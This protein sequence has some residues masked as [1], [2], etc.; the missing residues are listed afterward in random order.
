MGNDSRILIE[1]IKWGW[2][3][4]EE[5]PYGD[6]GFLLI[7]VKFR[8]FGKSRW[9]YNTYVDTPCFRISDDDLHDM[10][11]SDTKT[12]EMIGQ[13]YW[14]DVSSFEGLYLT[15][16]DEMI[17]FV[18]E[19]SD[20]PAASFIGFLMALYDQDDGDLDDFIEACKG[21]YTDDMNFPLDGKEE[22]CCP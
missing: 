7:S 14:M 1:N 10:F 13:V 15:E 6:T 20:H 3:N 11:L 5:D 4:Q 2:T 18:K 9:L 16:Y 19:H 8:Q 17:D 21:K 22:F 12:E